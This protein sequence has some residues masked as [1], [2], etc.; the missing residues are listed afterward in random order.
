MELPVPPSAVWKPFNFNLWCWHSTVSCPHTTFWSIAPRQQHRSSPD[1][2]PRIPWRLIINN[3]PTQIP[4]RF[5]TRRCG[6]LNFLLFGS[7]SFVRW[8]PPVSRV[9]NPWLLPIAA[10]GNF[11]RDIV[12]LAIMV[13]TGA[14]AADRHAPYLRPP[15]FP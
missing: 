6:E 5:T 2:R 1:N 13:M 11:P 4:S 8:G 10:T 12:C 7:F 14:A 3:V 9:G 15:F